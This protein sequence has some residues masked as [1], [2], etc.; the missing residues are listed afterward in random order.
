MSEQ[1]EE[2]VG[3]SAMVSPHELGGI[4]LMIRSREED[5]IAM[6]ETRL[7]ISEAAMLASHLQALITMA[8]QTVYAKQSQLARQTQENIVIPG[9]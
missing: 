9:R 8:W 3:L 5:G 1:E 7:D 4:K 6:R 2:F